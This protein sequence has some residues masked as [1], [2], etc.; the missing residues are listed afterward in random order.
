MRIGLIRERKIPADER[1]AFTPRQCV[2]VQAFFPGVKIVVAPSPIRCFKDEEYL[3]MGIEM[4]EDLSDCD[5][6]V[7]IK[8][9]PVEYLLPGKRY[10]F[11]SHTKKKQPHNRKMMQALIA[12]EVEMIDYECLVH[13]DEQRILGFGYF[14][15]IVGAYNGLRTY[16]LK[17]GLYQ[18]QPAHELLRYER[19]LEEYD[20]LPLPNVKIA[21]TGSGKV[22][23]GVMDLLTRLDVTNVEPEDFVSHSFDYP[24]FTQLK[25]ADLYVRKDNGLFHRDDFHANPE[26]YRCLFS[27]YISQSDLLMNGIYWDARIPRLFEKEDA[28]RFDW[29]LSVIADIT[30]DVEGSVPLNMDACT[31]QNPVYGVHRQTLER[32]EAYQHDAEIVDIMAVDNLPNELPRDSS[33]YFGAHLEK[34]V[35]PELLKEESAILERAT[36]CKDGRL[37]PRFAYLA[38]YAAQDGVTV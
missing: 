35:L 21:L 28:K 29:R 14:A 3:A 17:H 24:V 22:A 7:G 8:E 34:F 10:M 5:V 26:Q 23:S 15:G 4:N 18:V 1:V 20:D 37:T 38:D 25:G 2:H 19:I 32:M 13:A 9:V 36:I 31:I 12:R 30:C 33:K 11:F 27:N 16:G 6:L